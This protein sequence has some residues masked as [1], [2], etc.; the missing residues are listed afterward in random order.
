[1]AMRWL[2]AAN[3]V[4]QAMF[5]LLEAQRWVD[6]SFPYWR[7]RAGRDHI[8]CAAVTFLLKLLLLAR[9]AR[10]TAHYWLSRTSPVL[11]LL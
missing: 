6:T 8:W 5:M 3:R 4:M 9:S 1:M 7:R 11:T 2:V 10:M